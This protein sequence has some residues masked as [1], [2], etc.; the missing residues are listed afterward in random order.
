MKSFNKISSKSFIN[1]REGESE[2]YERL[3]INDL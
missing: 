2:Q 1:I 3:I